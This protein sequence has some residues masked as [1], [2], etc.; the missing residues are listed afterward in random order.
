[1]YTFRRGTSS[2]RRKSRY[3]L[4]LEEV[5]VGGFRAVHSGRT[6]GCGL[7]KLEAGSLLLGVWMTK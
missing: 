7:E 1:M 5:S 2:W 3:I 6:H 4:E